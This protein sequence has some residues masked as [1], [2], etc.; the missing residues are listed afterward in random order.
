ANRHACFRSMTDHRTSCSAILA[1]SAAAQDPLTSAQPLSR[2]ARITLPQRPGFHHADPCGPRLNTP[3]GTAVRNGG[4]PGP[5]R[6]VRPL[7]DCLTGTEGP[8]GACLH[9]PAP[10]ASRTG[11]SGSL[12]LTRHDRPRRAPGGRAVRPSRPVAPGPAPRR[13]EP[14]P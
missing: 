6:R 7:T 8:P 14:A 4:G 12:R 5:P 3:P 13:P 9:T 2:V 1:T 10:A 11:R